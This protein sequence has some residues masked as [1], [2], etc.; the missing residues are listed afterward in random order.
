M[1]EDVTP[2]TPPAQPELPLIPSRRERARKSSYRFRFGLIYVLLAGVVG[3]GVGAFIVLAAGSADPAEPAWSAWHPNGSKVMKVRQIADRIPKSYR[4]ENGSQLTVSLVSPL[5]VPTPQGNVPMRAVFVRPDT[6]KGLAEEDDIAVY[7]AGS[8]VSFGL[9]GTKSKEQCEVVPSSAE[10]DTLLRR[11]ALEL[12]LYT[13]KYVDSV[14]SVVVFLPTQPK[15]ATSK[16]VFLRRSDVT[17]E[18]D[19]PLSTLLPTLKPKV[20]ALDSLE[21]GEI[22]R[23]TQ[24]RTYAAEVQASP[25]GSP[26]LILTPPGAETG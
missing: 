13:L 23:L 3:A 19:S 25:D 26:I 7:P 16:T 24:S 9:C 18:L 5:E 20:G 6:S 12:S 4:A 10:R 14:D 22:L 2:A 15:D 21:E 8:V 11:Q 1:A 17:E